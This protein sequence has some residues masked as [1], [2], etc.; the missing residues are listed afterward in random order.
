MECSVGL[1]EEEV[2]TLQRHM[3]LHTAQ[4]DGLTLLSMGG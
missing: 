2:A 4:A 1:L 3:E